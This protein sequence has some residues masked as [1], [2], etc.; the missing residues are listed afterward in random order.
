MTVAV[1]ARSLGLQCGI[2][3]YAINLAERLGGFAV[4]SVEGLPVGS[5]PVFIQYEPSLYNG[6]GDLINEINAIS[7]TVVLDV[8]TEMPDTMVLDL[9]NIDFSPKTVII[10]VKTNPRPDVWFL[11]HIS[12]APV[13]VSTPPPRET[14]LGSFGFALP[15]K[16]Y[17]ILIDLAMR[18]HV[19]LTILAAH[20]N[21]T[22]GIQFLSERYVYS[23]RQ[24]ALSQANIRVVSRFLN[25]EEIIT[26]LRECSHLFSTMEDLG[27]TSGSMRMMALAD[28]PIISLP[29]KGAYEVD[30]IVFQSFDEITL[31]F[32]ETPHSLQS[33]P[34]GLD[35]YRRLLASLEKV[36]V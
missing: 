2:S 23:L 29:C 30:A 5:D 27:R 24:R 3:E 6:L 34:D 10:G 11:P 33:F 32:L 9:R 14:H 28:R 25:H 1:L 31:S 13:G 35:E 21:A 26:T 12:Y 15:N 17:E 20:A 19:P 4:S 18:L 16:R 36:H 22:P 7:G 8:H